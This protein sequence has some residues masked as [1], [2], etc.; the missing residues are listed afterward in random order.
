VT[1][2]NPDGEV[3]IQANGMDV[4]GWTDI[5]ISAGLDMIPS[6]FSFGMTEKSPQ[7]DKAQKL[8]PGASC[9]VKIGGDLVLTGY[10]N[11]VERAV[12]SRS[13]TIRV[14]G[15]SRCQDLVDNSALVPNFTINESSIGKVAA[16]LIAP[17]SGPIT[18]KLP[19]GDGANRPYAVSITPGETVWEVISQM[20][21]YEGKLVHDDA[22]GDLVICDVGKVEAGSGFKE[23]VNLQEWSATESDDMLHSQYIPSYSTPSVL[24]QNA[25]TPNQTGSAVIDPLVAR[26]RPVLVLSDQFLESIALA[27]LL[28]AWEA[29]RRRGRSQAVRVLADSWRDVARKLWTHNVLAPVDVPSVGVQNV[30]W[31]IASWNFVRNER[32]GT[33]A[34]ITLMPP[35]AFS[36][37]PTALNSTP[38]AMIADAVRRNA[39][40]QATTLCRRRQM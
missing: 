25:G 21:S 17:F 1:E 35:E 27:Q 31:I 37:M 12:T 16:A 5:S 9:T 32:R 28:A 33:V 22:T 26:Y 14:E 8:K 3:S 29:T 34:E 18:L 19:D 30:K 20:A 40:G 13:R 11:R 23:G 2:T 36:V 4:S 15:R 38:T 7:S 24:S 39:I 6:V 10:V